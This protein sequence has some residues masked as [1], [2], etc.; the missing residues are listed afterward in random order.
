MY[1]INKSKDDTYNITDTGTNKKGTNEQV[2]ANS[3][4]TL[5][6]CTCVTDI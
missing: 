3:N 2:N 5:Q 6:T 1:H 4:V